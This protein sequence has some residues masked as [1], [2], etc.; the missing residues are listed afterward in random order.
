MEKLTGWIEIFKAGRHPGTGALAQQDFST[1]DLDQMIANFDPAQPVPHVITHKELYSPFAYGQVVELRR[2]GEGLWARSERINPQ[3]AALV[4]AG[5][6][7]N[8][9][10][11]IYQTDR[12]YELGHVAWLGAEP[13]AVSG[14]APVE[15]SARIAFADYTIRP[16]GLDT[17][18]GEKPMGEFTKEQLE[19]AKTEAAAEATA[20]AATD[21][22]VRENALK[23][24]LLAERRA[25]ARGEWT[26]KV[27]TALAG[28]H[29]TPAQAEGVVDF[30]L[31]LP[32]AVLEY[33][34]GD[35]KETVKAAPRQWFADFIAK[36][37]KQV[38]LASDANKGGTTDG[39]WKDDPV[40]IADR[41]TE[42]RS[43]QQAKGIDVSYATAVAHVMEIAQ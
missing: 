10:V 17:G 4:A 36:L 7:Y 32:E 28:G 31:A 27:Q 29:L 37:P 22:T 33:S 30:A 34:K 1:A 43:A 24:E 35:G 18:T 40:Q 5:S 42:Y 39:S 13:P 8:R 11:R 21:F 3:F 23:A 12:G 38:A 25:I 2:E 20:K 26:A 9:S 6:L 41:A 14:L 16:F 15:F 19:A